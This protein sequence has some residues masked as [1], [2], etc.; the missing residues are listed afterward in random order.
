M[1]QS[2]IKMLPHSAA[3]VKLLKLYLD[4]YLSVLTNTSYIP[5]IYL[6]D[7]FC[8]EGVYEGGEGSPIIFLKTIRDVIAQNIQAGRK[9]PKYVCRFNDIE[10]DKTDRLRINIEKDGL[11]KLEGVTITY[12]NQDYHEAMKS[13]LSEVQKLTSQKAFVFIDPYGYKEVKTSDVGDLMRTLKAEVLLFLPTQFMFRFEAKGTPVSLISFIEELMPRDQWPRSETGIDFIENLTDSF[14][15]AFADFSYVDSFIITR[16]KNQYFCLFFFTSHIYGFD[17]MLDAK[18]S[19]DEQD[20]RGWQYEPENTLFSSVEKR[21]NT[22]RFEKNL[23]IYLKEKRTSAQVYEY[24]LNH[25]HLPKHANEILTK[26]QNEGRLDVIL[27][28]GNAARK[29]AF[30]LNYDSYKNE[31]EKVTIKLK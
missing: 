10:K 5:E 15:S 12:S 22:V 24:T 23:A 2:Q 29:K 17:R 21:P 7:L 20:G 14:K 31:P 16:D 9:N 11:D 19:I 25:S 13:T 26:W 30:Y 28:D 1:K 4:R 3:K 6:Y 27:S 18:W 8:S